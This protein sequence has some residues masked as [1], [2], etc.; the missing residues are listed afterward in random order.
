M[1]SIIADEDPITY[2]QAG[3]SSLKEKWTSA[4][5]DEMNALKNNETIDVVNKPI[6]H[7]IVSRKWV[8]K[9]KKNASSTL[10]TLQATAVAWQFSQAPGCYFEE[11]LASIIRDESRRLLHA[12]CARNKWRPHHFEVKSAFLYFKLKEEVYM[13]P[14]RGFSDGNKV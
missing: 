4:M 6:G 7:N 13:Q 14:Q 10:E 1:A 2:R 11:T 5:N 8:L 9:T 3:N 12:I